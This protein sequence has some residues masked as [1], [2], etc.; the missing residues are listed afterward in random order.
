MTQVKTVPIDPSVAVKR[1]VAFGVT[2]VF[3][4]QFVSFIF[5]NARNIAQPQM[6]AEFDGMSLFAWLIA[7]PAL[8]GSAS[9]LLFGKLSDMYGR[10][11]VLLISMAIFGVG[12]VLTTQVT[13]MAGLVTAATFMSIGHFPIVPLCFSVI[14]DLFSAAERARWT[15]LLNLPTGI[16]ATIGPV[17]GGVVAESMTGWRGLY[18]GTVPLLLIAGILVVMAFPKHAA[19]VKPKVDVAGTAVMI[20]AVATLIFGFSWIGQPAR[21]MAGVVLLVVS[22][23]A[24]W[25]FIAIEKKAAAPILDPQ[26]LFNR[27]FLTAA[28][29]SLFS[30]FGLLG[31]MAYSPIFVQEVMGISPTVS[32]SMLT[33]VTM[34]LAFM[35]IPGG[36]LLARTGKYKWMYNVGYLI[37]TLMLYAMWRFTAVTPIWV[38]VLVTAVAGFGLGA[39]PTIN[40]LVA[41]FAVP[42]RLLGVA[43]GAIFF[44]QM[45]G[46]AVA[47]SI[48]GLAQNSASNLEGGLKLVFLVGA[49]AMTVAF[50]LILTIPEVSIDAEV[51][52]KTAV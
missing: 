50:L 45:V 31:I 22:V 4:T 5:I 3:I 42:R 34:L 10:R 38:F 37:V 1:K 41:Q 48:L 23:A 9:T 49:V 13:S 17:L 16:A 6:I 12:L 18:W 52:D 43:V 8:A 44:F 30:F 24:W 7:M 27:T 2:A 21:L 15:G 14:G 29:A 11:A 20:I 25:G 35:G 19:Q 47:P 39:I 32:G 46:L 36:M 26:V 40:T 28:V 33:P 51:V